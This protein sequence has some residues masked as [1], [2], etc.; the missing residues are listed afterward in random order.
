MPGAAANRRAYAALDVAGSAEIVE[1]GNVLLPG[2]PGHDAQARLGGQI[3]QPD[4]RSGVDADCVDAVLG[5]GAEIAL[6][7]LW[8]REL[9]AVLAALEGAIGD[10]LDVQ[11]LTSR[12]QKL[13]CRM[14]SNERNL[15][16]QQSLLAEYRRCGP[17]E[18]IDI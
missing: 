11:F 10:A 1:E 15:R 2:N 17:T 5:H 8:R 13:G 12:E 3:E 14:G 16:R 6:D 18:I 4:G 7:D 9:G